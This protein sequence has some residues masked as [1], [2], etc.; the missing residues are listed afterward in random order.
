M[1]TTE[2]VPE[3]KNMC[4]E[5]MT[6]LLLLFEER[7]PCWDEETALLAGENPDGLRELAAA[8]LLKSSEGGY[9][10]TPKGDAERLRYAENA[11]V[12]AFEITPFNPEEALWNN[13]LYLLMERAFVGQ[14]GVKEYTLNEKLPVIPL[15]SRYNLWRRMS[16]GRV[17]YIWPEHPLI[18]SFKERF[19]AWG[20]AARKLPAPGDAAMWGW[21][22]AA[23]ADFCIQ[24]FN[25][26]LRS[27]YDFE[28]YRKTPHMPED[29]FYMKDADR[30]FFLRTSDK[31]ADEIYDAI[32]RL[33]LFLLGQRRVYI[34]GY[35]DIDSHE[36]E[37]WTMLVL[38]A[39][40]EEELAAIR[41]RYSY[42]GKNLIAPANPLFI[43][44][45]SIERLRRQE[46]PEP[47]V[48]DWFC[49]K[50]AHIV[51]PDV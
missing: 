14:F 5:D 15:I 20:V 28:L 48:Y 1:K 4:S 13:R 43:I 45:T 51:R 9:V 37:N 38:T 44:G 34:P 16:D 25:L 30:L 22:R 50:T 31:S 6:R 26:I 47:T 18:K 36:Q 19:P 41:K 2:A 35:A 11:G 32:G 17:K 27:R 10:L 39:D 24:S 3:R 29:I 40:N 42:D 23:G 21:T 33:H 49:D 7:F 8:G 46:E 12:P